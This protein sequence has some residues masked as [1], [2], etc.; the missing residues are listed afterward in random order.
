M[1]PAYTTSDFY[2]DSVGVEIAYS[3]SPIVIKYI[4]KDCVG[5][6]HWSDGLHQDSQQLEESLMGLEICPDYRF[7]EQ[8]I[9]G[10]SVSH[11]HLG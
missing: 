7:R 11:T 9:F 10:R 3:M 1:R 8:K 5:N 4:L 6:G 2:D